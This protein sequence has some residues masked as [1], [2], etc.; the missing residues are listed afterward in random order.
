MN[1][2]ER[3]VQQVHDQIRGHCKSLGLNPKIVEFDITSE[4]LI[5][6]QIPASHT[7]TATVKFTG[8]GTNN[9]EVLLNIN[10]YIIENLKNVLEP[11]EYDEEPDIID[12]VP[13]DEIF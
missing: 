1:R 12:Y 10:E 11:Q 6:L 8:R 7:F 13:D 5:I 4:N 2:K 9:V 3:F